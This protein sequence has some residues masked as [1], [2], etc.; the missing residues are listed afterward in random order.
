M[1]H[2]FD[3]DLEIGSFRIVDNGEAI[4]QISLMGKHGGTRAQ[5][6]E[7]AAAKE[8]ETSLIRKAS[9]QLREYLAGERREFDLPLAPQGTEF[10]RKAWAE[11]CRIP[12]G[13]TRSYKQI[14]EAIGSPK[15]FRAVGM[16]NNRNPIIIVIPCHRVIGANGGMVGYGGGLEVKEKLLALEGVL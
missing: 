15:G 4:T 7:A 16:A 9:E 3:Y 5:A 10:Q 6:E 1:N 13:E 8:E 14:A 2:F 11:L 12:Y